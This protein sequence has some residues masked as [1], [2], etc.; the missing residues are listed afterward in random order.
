MVV[1]IKEKRIIKG[2]GYNK[3]IKSINKG[4]MKVSSFFVS[5]L[6]IL[7]LVLVACGTSS[8][9]GDNP[10]QGMQVATLSGTPQKGSI[11]LVTPAVPATSDLG[12]MIL[13]QDDFSDPGSGW[14]IYSGEYGTA[15]YDQGRYVIEATV[16]KEYNWGVAGVN[17]DNIRI[18]VD[19]TA[20][21]TPA[22]LSDGFGV[23]C[24]IQEN[25][26]GYGFRVSSDG[27]A[28]IMVFKDGESTQLYDWTQST[29]VS[30][31]GE[32]N[33]ITAICEGNHFSLLV[34][35]AF[36]AEVVDDTYSSGDIAL[37]AISF[38]ADPV[39]VL[40]DDLIVQSIGDPYQYG[41]RTPYPVTITNNSGREICSVYISPDENDNWGDNWL[42]GSMTFGAGDT[43]TFDDN[44]NQV[45]DIQV[46]GCD[47]T[48]LYEGYS[49]DLAANSQITVNQPVLLKRYDFTSY[50]GWSMG[51]IK[52]G[53]TSITQGDYYTI[54]TQAG[55]PFSSGV[56]DFAAADVTLRADASLAKM[57]EASPAV[58]GVLC[59]VHED[60]SGI[61]F[62]LRSDGYGS[63]QKWDGLVLTPLTEWISSSSVNQG[64]NANYIEG[65]CNGNH[66]LLYI[67]GDY[68][69]ETNY[70][71][72]PT[73]KIG[74]GVV[75]DA[76]AAIK[77]DFDFVEVLEPLK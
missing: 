52:D 72:Y 66:F 48:R 59:R 12:P 76:S 62:A 16:E 30:P 47:T 3:I 37:S 15:G 57:G 10:A 11:E 44:L 74:V 36:V 39:K 31:A 8:S 53:T 14:E 55:G 24:R 58:Y 21:T 64:I 26:D 65:N 61:F 67:N 20:I 7:S 32:L 43:L 2:H 19:A 63:I 71:G 54:T 50:D 70:D 35:D 1:D 28:E 17:F 23:D 6:V 33:H 51:G 22:D 73:G 46:E 56:V 77:V 40:F 18:D 9:D 38:S 5:S 41:D 45:V 42:S 49:I 68:V 13:M 29:A 27:Y 69:T 34:N 4:I 60:G 75:P 25:G